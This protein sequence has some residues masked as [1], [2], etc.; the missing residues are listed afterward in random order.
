MVSRPRRQ[1]AAG[2]DGRSPHSPG[3]SR[4]PR[5]RA[6]HVGSLLRPPELRRAFRQLETGDLS[7]AEFSLL[8]D[9]VIR[10]AIRLQEEVGLEAIT[11]GEFRRMSYW[12]RFVDRVEGLTVAPASFRFRDEAGAEAAFLAPHVRA[13]VRRTRSI[14]GDE[15]DFVRGNTV[16][17][18]KITIPSPATMHFWRGPDGVDPAAYAEL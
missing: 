5:F 11:D 2:L 4:T 18:P 1:Q 16:R 6:D 10:A 17:T 9:E 15:Y 13:P 8:Q 3:M 7:P 12:A 14:A